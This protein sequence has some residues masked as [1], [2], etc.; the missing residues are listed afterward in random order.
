MQIESGVGRPYI[1]TE[2][3][4]DV[5]L[6][7]ERDRFGEFICEVIDAVEAL[8]RRGYIHQDLKPSNLMRRPSDGRLVLIDFGQAHRIEAGRLARRVDSLTM[9]SSGRRLATGTAGYCAPEQLEAE[10]TAFLPATD[11]YAIGMLIRN[12]GVH[13]SEWRQ[14]AGNATEPDPGRRIADLAK[15][16]LMVRTRSMWNLRSAR[17][18]IL[19]EVTARRSQT[20][21]DVPV[22]WRELVVNALVQRRRRMGMTASSGAAI[23]TE[24]EP[25]A[26]GTW[27][28]AFGPMILRVPGGT[29]WVMEEPLHF[30]EAAVVRVRGSGVLELAADADK[31]VIFIIEGEVTVVNRS[32]CP[33]GIEYF[34]DNGALLCFPEVA[35]EG[36]RELRRR[37]HLTSFDGA[38]VCYGGGASREEINAGYR[39]EWEA[40]VA[41]VDPDAAALLKDVRL[42]GPG[43]GIAVVLRP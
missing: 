30:T 17:Q 22:T 13:R 23:R 28:K 15:L 6:A 34:V 43:K 24:T 32:R 21:A 9:D 36:S 4:A 18:T 33:S 8:H 11:V 5:D 3:L 37:V 16:R 38:F 29:R 19:R 20:L 35:E 41:A 31:E 25:V 40:A 39:A 14:V 7:V 26:G 42:T 27:P 2:V 12:F 1:V 10:R